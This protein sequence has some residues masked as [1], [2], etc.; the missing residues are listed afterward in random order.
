MG[1][2]LALAS[3]ALYGAADFL[4]GLAS[5]SVNTIATV[6]VSR[7]SYDGSTTWA[8][9]RIGRAQRLPIWS[10]ILSRGRC[11]KIPGYPWAWSRAWSA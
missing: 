2:V 11:W 3:A 6:A 9:K 7:M 10:C 8:R 1:Y 4:G 5:R